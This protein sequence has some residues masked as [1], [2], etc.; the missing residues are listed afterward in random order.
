LVEPKYEI[1][2]PQRL[3]QA[4]IVDVP[5]VQIANTTA[6][7]PAQ[8]SESVPPKKRKLETLSSEGSTMAE[9]AI[10]RVSDVMKSSEL[11]KTERYEL[12]VRIWNNPDLIK[13]L[14]CLEDDELLEFVKDILANAY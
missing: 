13:F 3:D 12:K 11:S 9:A 6:I 1:L 2:A 4:P 14:G 7:A 8:A 5:V 10:R